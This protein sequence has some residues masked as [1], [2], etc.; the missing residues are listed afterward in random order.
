MK[1]LTKY[2]SKQITA[3]FLLC[4]FILV[5]LY[6][7][8]DFVRK[9]D[10]FAGASVPLS[11]TLLF[12]LYKIPI[13]LMEII[14][15]AT[16]ISIIAVICQMKKN[17]EVMAMKACG[18]NLHKVFLPVVAFSIIIYMFSLFLSEM[19][20]PYTSTRSNEIKEIEVKK[21]PQASFQEWYK[22]KNNIY[23][24]KHFDIESKTIYDPVFYFLN[25]QFILTK[26]INGTSCKW[27]DGVWEIENAK[28]LTLEKN[29]TYSTVRRPRLPLNI[30]ETP[31][32][33]ITKM[34][35]PEDRTFRELKKHAK[36]VKE[37]GYDNTSDLVYLYLKLSYPF[38]CVVLALIAVPLGL[39]KK[40]SGIPL[41][42]TLGIL[43]F[44]ILLMLTGYAR[45]FGL[46]GKLPPIL[47]AWA[48]NVLFLFLGTYLFMNIKK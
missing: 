31:E 37:E 47:A 4:N 9:I 8:I 22:S 44:F 25:D 38:M 17:K 19:I 24:I 29:N 33:F 40:V 32:T 27:L 36:K 34:R 21:R 10:N 28:I 2:I 6:L 13:M 1:V 12:F 48:A 43:T 5:M 46:A 16:M 7:V 23:W 18:L 15:A 35:K 45:A 41:S 42:V 11:L 30:P 26:K 39:W 3:L 20:V 14:P